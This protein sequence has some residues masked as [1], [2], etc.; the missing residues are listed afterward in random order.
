MDRSPDFDPSRA[1]VTTEGHL[2]EVSNWLMP[3]VAMELPFEA[4]VAF[5]TAIKRF[6]SMAPWTDEDDDR[7]STLVTPHVGTDWWEET[8]LDSGVTVAH[9]VR[10]KGYRLLT[11][12][13]GEGATGS[14]F[15]RVFAGPVIPGATPHP[16]KVKFDLGGEA[17]PGVWHRRGEEIEDERVVRLFEE[18]D[19][20]DVMVAGDFV[21]VGLDRTSS[22]EDRLD[23]VLDIVTALFPHAERTRTARTRDELIEEGRNLGAG[24]RPEELHLLNPDDPAARAR[25]H[26]ALT[27]KDA[28]IRRI[29][30]A[31]LTESTDAGVAESAVRTGYEDGSRIVRRTAVDTAADLRTEKLRDLFV[32]ALDDEDAWIRWKA[33]RSLG[34]LG[35]EQSRD[36]VAALAND[37]NF[38]VRFEVASVLR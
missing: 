33:V 36:E 23:A 24:S 3:K 15:D 14:I 13:L 25:L 32:A 9:G 21:T 22:W 7:L 27:G 26:E 31:V 28:R 34:D 6:F 17:S 1:S 4:L 10:D 18:A 8:T 19:I 16:R 11:S 2:G 29:A 5:K 30:V 38:Q 20:T 37:D 35:I 12:G